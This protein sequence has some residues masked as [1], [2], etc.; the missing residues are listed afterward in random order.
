[1]TSSWVAG[2]GSCWLSPSSSASGPSGSPWETVPADRCESALRPDSV[3]S[4]FS[5]GR[6]RQ[7]VGLPPEDPTL[8][9]VPQGSLLPDHRALGASPL[10]AS[11]LQ[12]VCAHPLGC[13]LSHH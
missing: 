10:A 11:I 13:P 2:M 4:L 1:M 3:L 12:E 7:W 5:C 6:G 9:D 8:Q